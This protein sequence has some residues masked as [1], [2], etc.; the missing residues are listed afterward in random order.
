MKARVL[1]FAMCLVS[2][3]PL[4]G[5]ATTGY[6]HMI[7][8]L[9]EHSGYSDGWP[10]STPRDYYASAKTFG[11]DFLGSGEHSDSARLPNVFSENCLTMELPSCALADDDQ[12]ANS[13]RKWDATLEYAREATDG[14]FTGF[15][16]FE[17]TS[18]VFGHLNVYFSRNDANAKADGGYARMEP[19]YTWFTT[20]P[21]LGG[22]AD[23]IATF[24]HPGDKCLLGR[25]DARCD[26]NQYAYVA[27]ADERMVGIEMFNGSKSFDAYYV[28]ALDR[29]W[30]VGAVGAEDK[31]HDRPDRWGAPEWAK[32]VILTSPR[33]WFCPGQ[34]AILPDP[35]AIVPD[36]G[37]PTCAERVYRDAM[38][39]RRMYA[40]QANHTDVRIDLATNDGQTMGARLRKAPGQA[41]GLTATVSGAGVARLDL[42]SNGGAIVATAAGSAI[43]YVGTGTSSERYYYLRVSD[44]AGKP[45]AYG[46]PVWVAP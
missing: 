42:I 33:P 20:A 25:T 44:G 23:G 36:A 24:N 30:H 8:A 26:W 45:I 2:L 13:F 39:A 12:P 19:F 11:M 46:S 34:H 27:E 16:G 31:G 1:A 9:H 32:T 40:V 29:G 3:A 38:L 41:F 4:Q 18:D 28:K 17:Y 7:G 14:T 35:D 22:G 10:G 37:A 5:R 43:S 15:R 21:E 6:A